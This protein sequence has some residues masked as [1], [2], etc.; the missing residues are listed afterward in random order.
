MLPQEI[1]KIRRSEMLFLA[2]SVIQ[3]LRSFIVCILY[4][5]DS[6]IDGSIF[7]CYS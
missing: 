2:I 5:H 1:L 3:L 7:I 6:N 4:S